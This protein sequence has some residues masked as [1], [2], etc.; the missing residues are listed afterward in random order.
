MKKFR[1]LLLTAAMTMA[2]GITALASDWVSGTWEQ[3]ADG[4][5]F[6]V[7]G[8]EGE[9]LSN[10]WAWIDG[11]N[12]GTAEC[13]YFYDN[14]YMAENTVVDGYPVNGEGQWTDD[15]G[16]VQTEK[17]QQNS[18]LGPGGAITGDYSSREGWLGTYYSENGDELEVN[19]GADDGFAVHYYPVSGSEAVYALS[20][21]SD[22]QYTYKTTTMILNPDGT[23]TFKG[24][25][26]D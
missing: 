3:D 5:K 21:V 14:D 17:K 12:N 9:Y 10:T 15:E 11:D 8:D 6:A 20:K 19:I 24:K 26:F 16:V 7:S 18:P 4:W 2:M 23:I 22:S 25:L 1:I 13:Y